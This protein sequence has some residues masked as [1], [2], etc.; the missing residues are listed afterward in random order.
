MTD[1]G[2]FSKRFGITKC[3]LSQPA[4]KICGVVRRF[5]SIAVTILS[6]FG[7]FGLYFKTQIQSITARTPHPVR[8]VKALTSMEWFAI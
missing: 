7:C 5:H 2:Q 3:G 6:I 8:Y 1:I 4:K